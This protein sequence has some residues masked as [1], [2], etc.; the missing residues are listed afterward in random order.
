MSLH[1]IKVSEKNAGKVIE[2]L[3]ELGVGP[4]D[5]NDDNEKIGEHKMTSEQ[6]KLWDDFQYSFNKLK[7]IKDEVSLLRKKFWNKVEGDLELFD[8]QLKVNTDNNTIEVYEKDC[9]CGEC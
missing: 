4:E 2:L 8:K 9:D 7:V 1:E 5:D 6:I 3:K